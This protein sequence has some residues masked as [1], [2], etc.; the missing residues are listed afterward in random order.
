MNL[1]LPPK[2]VIRCDAQTAQ[3]V[4]DQLTSVIAGHPQATTTYRFYEELDSWLGPWGQ[5]GYPLGY[6]KFYN[7]AF[8]TNQKLMSNPTTK[9]WVWLTT[10]RLQEALRD[11]VVGRIR[12]RS[13]PSLTEP[14]LRQAAFNSH[15]QAYDRG[16]LATVVL[17]APELIPII[18]TIPGAEF[19]PTAE[20]FGPTVRQV[21]VTLALV[22]SK[23]AGAALA[24]TAGPAHTRIFR[25]A[26]HQDQQRFLNQLA[27]ARELS[28]LKVLINGG[29]LDHIPWLDE[30]IAR[31]NAREFPD[32]GFAQLAREVVQ[33]AQKRRY[34]LVQNYNTLMNQSPEVRSR[35]ERAFP[36][37]LG[38]AE[39]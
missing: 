16:G 7:I 10:I 8:M 9:Q 15:P 11:Y 22:S 2:S 25:W 24:T 6:G 17:V 4:H 20:N 38:P 14:E 27:I 36:G 5:R 21:F 34:Q 12:D 29:E 18:A 35:V 3:S 32:Q 33:I 37:I 1:S 13:L 28:N 23:V 26:V 31:L 30:I 39:N 19:N